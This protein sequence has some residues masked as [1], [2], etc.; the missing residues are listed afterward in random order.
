MS[1]DVKAK[2]AS[3]IVDL[4]KPHNLIATWFGCGLMRKA[5]GTWGSLGALPFGIAIYYYGG[6]YALEFCIIISFFIG[7]WAAKEFDGEHG[8]HDSK[9]IVIDEVS[10]QWLAMLPALMFTG[11]NPA[12]LVLSFGAFRFFDI[13]KPWPVSYFD[14]KVGGALGV[15]GDDIIAGIFAAIVI[16]GVIYAGLA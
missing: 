15:M 3:I 5:P 8:T 2:E 4:K 12:L 10:G 6:A 11:Y 13:L 16:Y 7:L 9:M 1:K 14:K